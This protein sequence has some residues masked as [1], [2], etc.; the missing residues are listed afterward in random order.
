MYIRL[1]RKMAANIDYKNEALIA[2]DKAMGTLTTWDW[3]H[4][5]RSG[6]DR[7]TAKTIDDLRKKVIGKPE[8]DR[9]VFMNLA[10]KYLK[11]EIVP[12][13]SVLKALGNAAKDLINSGKFK[14]AEKPIRA[15][16]VLE[17]KLK[18]NG[19]AAGSSNVWSAVI[20]KINQLGN[21]DTGDQSLTDPEDAPPKPVPSGDAVVDINDHPSE[22]I[23]N[24]LL[25]KT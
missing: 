8:Q 22:D 2:I 5:F 11:E 12:S 4:E 16:E 20:G 18:S 19:D 9:L 17:K 7:V 23:A 24:M 10:D 21:V 1:M 6:S 25:G 15:A 14:E 13:I 3:D